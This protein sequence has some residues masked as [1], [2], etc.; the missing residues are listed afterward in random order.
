M[1]AAQ[2]RLLGGPYV[3]LR[4]GPSTGAE[5][6]DPTHTQSPMPAAKQ[7][8]NARR[9]T[10]AA[11]PPAPIPLPTTHVQQH[12]APHPDLE[13]FANLIGEGWIESEPGIY[14]RVENIT[15]PS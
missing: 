12:P 15:G 1:E 7:K 9:A 10:K 2:E 5:N 8:G 13:T 6:R 11:T 14:Y 4:P 3:Y